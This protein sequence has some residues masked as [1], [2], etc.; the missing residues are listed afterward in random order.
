MIRWKQKDTEEIKKA[1]FLE[2]LRNNNFFENGFD[3]DEIGFFFI[4][5]CFN[6]FEID[7]LEDTFEPL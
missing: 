3:T 6:E 1:N 4:D 2:C 7:E 5:N